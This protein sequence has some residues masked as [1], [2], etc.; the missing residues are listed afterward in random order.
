MFDFMRRASNLSMTLF[1][2]A[3]GAWLHDVVVH[4]I[5]ALAA[6]AAHTLAGASLGALMVGLALHLGK[7]A[8]EARSW[9]AIVSHAH[10]ASRIRFRTT[11]GAF[12]GSI[13]AN[14]VLPARV[15]EALRLGIMRRRVPGSTVST[16]A[17]TIVLETA[18][19]VVFGLVVIGA[20]LIAGRSVGPVGSPTSFFASHLVTLGAIGGAAIVLGIIG[21]I[22]RRHLARPA[23]A[24]AQGMSVVRA[25]RQLLRGVMVWKL[26][27]WTF[28][29]AAVYCFLLAFHLGGGLWVVLLVVA[30]QNLAGLLPLA[31]GSAGTQQAVLAF[32]L[33]GTVSAAAVVGFGVG[34]QLATALADVAIGVVAVALVS[35]WSDVG[36]ALRPSRRRLAPVS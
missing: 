15:G 6:G 33:A 28:R 36:D 35:S 9:H 2:R 31:P 25:P 22:M 20:V 13:G 18:I 17:G 27:A 24:M 3:S 12:A 16:I 10:P 8:A 23:R 29:F 26:L 1:R 5:L 14:A 21:W 11:L 4:T 34:M 7:V 32:A 19:E 30:A